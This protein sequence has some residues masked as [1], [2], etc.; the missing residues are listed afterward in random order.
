MIAAVLMAA[1]CTNPDE[2][3]GKGS[4]G[5]SVEATQPTMDG[6]QASWAAG[7]QIAAFSGN[8]LYALTGAGEG[9]TVKF[10]SESGNAST[11]Y[12]L[13]PYDESATGADNVITTTFP[14]TQVCIADGISADALVAVAEIAGGKADFKAAS[15]LL[16]FTVNTTYNIKSIA[17]SPKGSEKIA[18]SAKITVAATPKV[19][20]ENGVS[21][22]T[23]VP[24]VDMIA[25]GD[26]YA[27]VI[28]QTYVDGFE[29]ILADE[30]G[31]TA[32]VTT[33]DFLKVSAGKALDLGNVTEGIE[34]KVPQLTQSPWDLYA[35]GNG[36]T[37]TTTLSANVKS[38]TKVDAPSYITVDIKGNTLSATFAAND[39]VDD[40]RFGKIYAEVITDEGPA[41]ITILTAQAFKGGICFFD[42]FTGPEL[43]E[44]WKG[45]GA[46]GRGDWKYGEGYLQ[47]V[48]TGEVYDNYAALYQGAKFDWGR[49]D[50]SGAGVKHFII[51]TDVCMDGGCGGPVCFNKAGYDGTKYDFNSAQ[52]YLVFVAGTVGADG[53]GYY[54]ANCSSFNAMDNANAPADWDAVS[55][56]TRVEIGNFSRKDGDSVNNDWVNKGLWSLKEDANGVLQKAD[57]LHGG[58]MWWWNDSPAMDDTPGYCGVFAKDASA[59]K[60]KNFFV[61]V[62]EKAIA[63]E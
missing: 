35:K 51:Y 59:T 12:L 43:D 7:A 61:A 2:K 23:M 17:I 1:S 10:E 54:V 56:W 31:R 39:I 24:A 41:T 5:I 21:T 25:D 62:G 60:F 20:V 40:A 34:F 15:G 11:V 55:P 18:G 48:G 50:A 53:I 29:I 42:S 26:Y 28:P 16:K 9:S 44:N 57:Y 38:V 13:T 19:A 8:T 37:K 4:K 52:N 33:S 3:G 6:V 63:E 32:K 30:F 58:A 49:R 45:N 36:E 14:A 27:A 46:V 47:M 22:I